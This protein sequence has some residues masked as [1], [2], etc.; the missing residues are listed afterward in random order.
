MDD[1]EIQRL[2]TKQRRCTSDELYGF[3]WIGNAIKKI[4]LLRGDSRALVTHIFASVRGFIN[5]FQYMKSKSHLTDFNILMIVFI[6]SL[7]HRGIR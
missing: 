4:F 1:G 3:A 6:C 2:I 7:R 5:R